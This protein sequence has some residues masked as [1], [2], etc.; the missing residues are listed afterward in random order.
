MQSLLI[1]LA[2]YP[3][4]MVGVWALVMIGAIAANLHIPVDTMPLVYGLVFAGLTIALI[5]LLGVAAGVLALVSSAN[6][7]EYAQIFVPGRTAS[8]VDFIAGFAG[9]LVAVILVWAAR[10]LV[11]RSQRE[12]EVILP[13][14]IAD[15]GA[16]TLPDLALKY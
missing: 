9:V 13:E 4:V 11:H 15:D 12:D 8:A 16:D 2:I 10:I 6:L 1:S 5:D 3:I 7:I 14:M